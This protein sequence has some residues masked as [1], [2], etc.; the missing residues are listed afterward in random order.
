MVWLALSPQWLVYCIGCTLPPA[1][2]LGLVLAHLGWLYENRLILLFIWSGRFVY[3]FKIFFWSKWSKWLAELHCVSLGS[4]VHMMICTVHIISNF[5][6]QH[7]ESLEG[8]K[9]FFAIFYET[10]LPLIW[11]EKSSFPKYK[12][13][14]ISLLKW[15]KFGD[16]AL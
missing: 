11:A 2:Q 5:Y 8:R 3:L 10:S 7:P 12:Y 4:Q 9:S 1:G 14:L 13:H 15:S 16:S 6:P